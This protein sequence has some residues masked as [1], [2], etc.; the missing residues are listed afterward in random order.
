M[1]MENVSEW[2]LERLK[3]AV[4]YRPLQIDEGFGNFD[5]CLLSVN[6][7]TSMS[8]DDFDQLFIMDSIIENAFFPN[9]RWDG[10]PEHC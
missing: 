10:T 2:D 5:E 3:A 9:G 7:R 8:V 6:S 4:K 1:E